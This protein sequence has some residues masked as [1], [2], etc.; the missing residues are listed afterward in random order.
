M[1]DYSILSSNIDYIIHS[2]MR[3]FGKEQE[4]TCMIEQLLLYAIKI[5]EKFRNDKFNS[6]KAYASSELPEGMLKSKKMV[7][8][9]VGFHEVPIEKYKN[10]VD[11]GIALL[12]PPE[13]RKKNLVNYFSGLS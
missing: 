12:L 4:G 6:S 10:R 5:S 13:R 9:K 11:Q 7:D 2:S 3:R 8:I 1:I